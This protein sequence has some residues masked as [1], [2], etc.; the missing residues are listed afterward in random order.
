MTRQ[1]RRNPYRWDLKPNSPCAY[2]FGS[3]ADGNRHGGEHKHKREIRR[4]YKRAK[5][6]PRLVEGLPA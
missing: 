1:E 4:Y 5:T 6:G 2:G 3:I